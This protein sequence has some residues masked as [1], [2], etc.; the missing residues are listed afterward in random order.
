MMSTESRYII[1]HTDDEM[2]CLVYGYIRKQQFKNSHPFYTIPKLVIHNCLLYY[3]MSD[4]KLETVKSHNDMTSHTLIK[5][6]AKINKQHTVNMCVLELKKAKKI[7]NIIIII[8]CRNIIIF[9]LT[10]QTINYGVYNRG[11]TE[12]YGSNYLEGS[13]IE[14]DPRIGFI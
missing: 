11:K 3:Y 5:S 10:D 9:V 1:K 7:I 2:K 6:T 14:M 13:V 4:M 8:N 12:K